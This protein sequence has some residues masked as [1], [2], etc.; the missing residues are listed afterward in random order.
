MEII[1]RIVKLLENPT[2]T[3]VVKT[4]FYFLGIIAFFML[5]KIIKA[6][7]RFIQEILDKL[8]ELKETQEEQ[9]ISQQA[10]DAGIE[11]V[12]ANGK[13][14]EYADY[15]DNTKDILKRELDQRKINEAFKADRAKKEKFKWTRILW[16]FWLLIIIGTYFIN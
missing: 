7:N 11:K 9:H 14:K 8:R 6:A 4:I 13:G 12:I 5:P 16:P 10:M 1:D 2:T 15:R 3:Q